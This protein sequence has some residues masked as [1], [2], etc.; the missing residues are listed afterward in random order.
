MRVEARINAM[1]RSVL[2]E[3]EDLYRTLFVHNHSPMLV[4]DPESAG[5]VDANPAACTFYGYSREELTALRITDVNLLTEEEVVRETQRAR[6]GEEQR[7]EFQHRL[8]NGTIRE[9]E[10]HSSPM[11]V[12]GRELLCSVIHDVTERKAAEHALRISAQRWQ[13][14]FD[15]IN[16]A[17][18][19]MSNEYRI[20]QCNR[21]MLELVGKA[22]DEIM[23]RNCY[24]LMHGSGIPMSGCPMVTM[25][26][27]QRR[28]ITETN[29][30]N[31]WYSV[32]ADP[33]VDE[34]NTIIGAVHILSDITQAKL[35]QETLRQQSNE[36]AG[37]AR[38]FRST[39]TQLNL[40]TI[41]E[42]ALH[43]AL[44]L[45]G[46]EAGVL[47]VIDSNT[48]CLQPGT[49]VN[50]S[51]AMLKA[52]GGRAITAGESQSG[53]AKRPGPSSPEGVITCGGVVECCEAACLEGFPFH[54]A[55]PLKVR[56]ETIGGLC[57]F[58]PTE[59]RPEQ[60]RLELVQDISGPVALAIDNARLYEEVQ[61][62]AAD[63]EERV[64]ERTAELQREIGDRRLIE[65]ALRQS[66]QKYREL[67]ENANS[68]ILRMDAEG[69][70]TFLNEFAQRFFGFTER[71][72]LGRYVVGTIVPETDRNGRDLHQMIQDLA[73][74]PERYARNE[75]ENMRANGERAWIAWTNKP[76][77]DVAGRLTECLCIGNDIT[78][79]KSVEEELV[80]AKDAAEAA[81][82]IK[83]AFLAT[84]SHELRTPLNSIIGFTGILL[85]GLAGPLNEEQNKQLGMVQRSSRHLLELIN[86]VLDISKIEAG[87]LELAWKPFDLRESVAKTVQLVS[88][89]A[90]K[91]GLGMRLDISEEVGEIESD[92]R[93][94]EQIML[95]L[96]NNA[97]KFT[98]EGHI[99]VSC[100]VSDDQVLLSVSDTGIGM[101]PEDAETIFRPFHQID[102]GLARKHE[103]TG[104]GLS[105][106]KRLLEMM[107]GRIQVES[108]RGAG[109]TFTVSLPQRKGKP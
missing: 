86:D 78:D 59:T 18:C 94:L 66:E 42:E 36:M 52:L 19:L 81:D 101:L 11:K 32:I 4:I 87:Q 82:R 10:V 35:A 96:L 7:F 69:R 28:E 90:E 3:P 107:G 31:R 53:S 22:P 13:T 38:L 97:V 99:E 64:N 41:L 6:P 65:G 74:H 77:F 29:L 80:H 60:R 16:D 75:N 20:L 70:I 62:Y 79:L 76:I 8:A 71:E 109:S 45:T 108:E 103:G 54:A 106:C 92:Q 50:V 12:Q 88:P 89:L 14:T 67:V 30:L 48:G 83:S 17:I 21:A 15:A 56:N 84:M 37:L 33:I 1:K 63:L 98:D 93:R 46:L 104:L 5:I 43:G 39:T 100:R 27:T 85:Q 68:I 57:L 24:E 26:K 44:A 34:S 40:Q 23:G 105:I 9:V 25:R 2:P 58:F 91:K 61:R 95:N 47:C 49:A 72:I 102:T 73:R 55:F 51:E